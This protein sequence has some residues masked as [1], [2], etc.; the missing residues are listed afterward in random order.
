MS[1][2]VGNFLLDLSIRF[3]GRLSLMMTKSCDDEDSSMTCL[4][5]LTTGSVAS[6]MKLNRNQAV[7][8]LKT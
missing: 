1:V 7:S 6:R 4:L 5:L 8:S 3:Q 2:D